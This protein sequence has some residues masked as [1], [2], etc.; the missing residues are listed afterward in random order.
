MLPVGRRVG[1]AKDD[2]LNE[3]DD[4]LGVALGDRPAINGLEEERAR[5]RD[6]A[7]D[8]GRDVGQRAARVQTVSRELEKLPG[9]VLPGRAEAGARQLIQKQKDH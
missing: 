6:P 4:V 9:G 8:A 2:L 1:K 5:E 7:K 3:L